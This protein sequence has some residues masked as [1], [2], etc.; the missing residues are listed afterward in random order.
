[1][2]N[3]PISDEIGLCP[4]CNTAKHPEHQ[5]VYPERSPYGYFVTGVATGNGTGRERDKPAKQPDWLE[6][7]LYDLA[8]CANHH[9]VDSP[10]LEVKVVDAVAQAKA[11][12]EAR[13]TERFEKAN[14]VSDFVKGAL[15]GKT[16]AS[17]YAKGATQ[18]SIDTKR[19]WYGR[20]GAK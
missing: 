3:K 14:E 7:V 1:M 12:I 18:H 8:F 9:I 2:T 17:E 19:R 4:H 13:Y 15:N 11:T 6:E 5:A 20:E 10:S 16:P